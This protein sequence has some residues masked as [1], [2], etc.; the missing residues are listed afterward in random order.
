M[1]NDAAGTTWTESEPALTDPRYLGQQEIRG[2]RT[3]VRLRTQREHETFAASTAGGWHRAGSAKAYYQSG[4][5]S[6]RPDAATALNADDDGRLWVDSDDNKLYVYVDPGG[7]EAVGATLSASG[8][9]DITSSGVQT[10]GGWTN[11]TGASVLCIVF[12]S[13]SAGAGVKTLEIDY[14]GGWLEIAKSWQLTTLGAYIC[15]ASVVVP[16][17]GKLRVNPVG[18]FNGIQVRYQQL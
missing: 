5:P 18:S 14:G 16:N 15:Y 2:L 13:N 8:N 4:E 11:S 17:T 6:Q 1:A 10:A 12:W 7:F 3:G 9:T